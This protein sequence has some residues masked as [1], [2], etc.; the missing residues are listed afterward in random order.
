MLGLQPGVF[1]KTCVFSHI[2]YIG[3]LNFEYACWPCVVKGNNFFAC[4]RTP[5]LKK[6]VYFQK[7][8]HPKHGEKVFGRSSIIGEMDCAWGGLTNH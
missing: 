2:V 7:D 3:A 1:F 4:S 8:N 6:N 5:T